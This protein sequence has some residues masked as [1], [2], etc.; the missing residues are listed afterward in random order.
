MIVASENVKCCHNV[1]ADVFHSLNLQTSNLLQPILMSDNTTFYFRQEEP[2]Q[3]CFLAMRDLI[4][5][6]DKEIEETV[7]FGCPCFLYRGKSFC[8][9]W[10]DK[11]TNEPYF[12]LVEGK[13]LTHSLL[14]TGDRKRMKI[15]RVNPNEDLP[16]DTINSVLN[17]ALNLYKNG[18]IKTK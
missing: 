5:K 16:I 4:M 12:L 13:R 10:K 14:E 2:N 3:S 1:K 6:A 11:K 15:L 9:L 18:I 8:Y 7:K 17:E